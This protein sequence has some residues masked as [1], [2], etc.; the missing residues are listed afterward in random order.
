MFKDRSVY[1]LSKTMEPV[2][3]KPTK[4]SMY[5]ELAKN[6]WTIG[7]LPSEVLKLLRNEVLSLINN[8]RSISVTIS[9]PGDRICP[10]VEGDRPN[11]FWILIFLI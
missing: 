5:L 8:S 10:P 11:F 6:G 2:L 7:K 9:T 3:I 1:I 4:E